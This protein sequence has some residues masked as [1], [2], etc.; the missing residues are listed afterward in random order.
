VLR[1]KAC[2]TLPTSFFFLCGA[3]DRT[4]SLVYIK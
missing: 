1:L 4:Q 3:E 2:V